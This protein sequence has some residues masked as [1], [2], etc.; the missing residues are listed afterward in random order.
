MTSVRDYA[1]SIG[2]EILLRTAGAPAFDLELARPVPEGCLPA[3]MIGEVAGQ[4][5]RAGIDQYVV[6][7]RRHGRRC[8]IIADTGG[9]EGTV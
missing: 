6:R 2:E 9:I 4:R 3:W 7:V 5:R 8:I 1:Y